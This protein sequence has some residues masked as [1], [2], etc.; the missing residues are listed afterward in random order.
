ME[1]RKFFDKLITLNLI[2]SANC[3]IAQIALSYG[4]SY[5]FSNSIFVFAFFTG[6]YLMSM[7][8]G[9]LVVERLT[10]K[11]EQLIQCILINSVMGVLLANPGITGLLLT[12]EYLY[13]LLRNHS[14]DLLYLMFPLG[15]ILTIL[16]GL[17]SGSE[18]PI[19]SKLI[20]TKKWHTSK[21]IIGV[22]T[23]DYFGAFTGVLIFT[24]L[25]NPFVGLV[26]AILISQTVTILYADFIY[27]KERIMTKNKKLTVTLLFINLYVVYF[28]FAQKGF[29]SLLDS[30][31]GI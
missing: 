28:W 11:S 7:G 3:M 13:A 23:S 21:P 30:I 15:F 10:L 31:S 26:T 4:L 29:T 19:F 25:L 24:L 22:L 1:N 20:E 17:V 27:F 2:T 12:N 5:I 8:L 16:I 6:L 18:L 14:I 9:T